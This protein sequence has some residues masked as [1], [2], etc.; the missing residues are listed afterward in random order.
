MRTKYLRASII[1]QLHLL[2]YFP[3]NSLQIETTKKK[4][5]KTSDHKN[6]HLLTPSFFSNILSAS[7]S[8]G[9]KTLPDSQVLHIIIQWTTTENPHPLQAGVGK[10]KSK[11]QLKMFYDN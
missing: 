8:S 1:D 6:P 5:Q 7:P 3:C 4:K 2:F 10:Q 11:L 9:R